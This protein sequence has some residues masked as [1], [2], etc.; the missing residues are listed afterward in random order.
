MP[1]DVA[2]LVALPVVLVLLVA[3]TACGGGGDEELLDPGGLGVVDFIP[4]PGE[5]ADPAGELPP[6]ITAVLARFVIG[7]STVR[8]WVTDRGAMKQLIAIQEGRGSWTHFSGLLR[9]GPGVENENVPWSWHIDGRA[10]IVNIPHDP[11]T[12]VDGTPEYIETNH[13]DLIRDDVHYQITSAT[14]ALA[15]VV[16]Y[17]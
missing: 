4:V 16:V 17:R 2:R 12:S 1:T 6:D 7:S 9:P 10:V 14:A 8:V 11:L 3:L 13:E 5:E 15:E